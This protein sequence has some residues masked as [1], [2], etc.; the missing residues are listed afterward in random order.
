MEAVLGVV[1]GEYMSNIEYVDGPLLKATRKFDT[2][3]W[4]DSSDP[5]ELRQSIATGAVGATCNP[6]IAYTTISKYPEIWN[7][8]IQKIAE[9]HPHW[10]EEEIGVQAT[11]DMS[12]EAAKLLLPAFEASGGRDG[13][14]SVQ[15]SPRYYRSPQKLADQAVE[16]S[17][18]APNI[19]VKV[20]ATKNGI[21]AIEDAT[22]RGVSMN[23][24]VSFSVPQALASAEAIERG[25]NRRRAEGLKVDDM[26]PVVTIM[27]GRLDDWLKTVVK[28]EGLFLDYSA[29][30]W[31]G[32]A[33]FKRAYRI[34][35]E[36]DYTARLLVAAFRN[37]YQWAEFQGG[38]VV[39]SPPFKW[40]QIVQ[41]SDYEPVERMSIPVAEHYIENLN[42]IEDF[43]RAYEP[44][45]MTIEEFDT[46]GPTRKTLRGFLESSNDL[47]VLVRNV[48]IAAP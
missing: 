2:V 26:G 36:R 20:P 39:V 23:V 27:V 9:E 22:Y 46:F 14:V 41:N 19:V 4:N 37:P 47:D 29:L 44:D 43:R 45:G 17:E 32:I 7:P 15:T 18:L 16:F 8:R 31:A 3:L 33:A 24:T 25:L 1:P 6:T 21:E 28:R 34:F 48:L 5:N 11:K 42:R 10:S 40:Q 35:Q 12:V 13:R 30:E 38:D